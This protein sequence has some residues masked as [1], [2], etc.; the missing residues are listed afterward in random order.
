MRQTRCTSPW[1]R[2]GAP[3]PFAATQTETIP[4]GARHVFLAYPAESVDFWPAGDSTID[5]RTLYERVIN[6]VQFSIL[7]HVFSCKSDS[8]PS[9]SS[10]GLAGVERHCQRCS[11]T[12]VSL[13]AISTLISERKSA[14]TRFSN[15]SR[16]FQRAKRAFRSLVQSL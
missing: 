6:P 16:L 7:F 10:P 2:H 15:P 14:H 1:P 4:H 11:I 13:V 9:L 3:T 5:T 12:P 8:F